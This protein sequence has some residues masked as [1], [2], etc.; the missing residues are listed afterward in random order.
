MPIRL[1]AEIYF[2]PLI[3][4]ANVYF[5]QIA[6]AHFISITHPANVHFMLI[7]GYTDTCGMNKV[8]TELN[9]SYANMYQMTNN[10][11]WKYVIMSLINPSC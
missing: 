9:R 6:N 3:Y 5:M 10:T 7:T 2:M 11:S 8:L 1:P 4:H